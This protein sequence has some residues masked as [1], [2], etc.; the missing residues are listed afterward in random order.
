L[1]LKH[2]FPDGQA[3]GVL[4]SLLT[5]PSD[6]VIL[7]VA[8]DGTAGERNPVQTSGGVGL[9]IAKA[10]VMQLEGRM[11]VV[12]DNGTRVMVTMPRPEAA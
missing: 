5:E 12:Q 4:V 3:G 9:R 1:G 10:L 7:A 2:G 6:T 11:D 8:D